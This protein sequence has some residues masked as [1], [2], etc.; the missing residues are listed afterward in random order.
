MAMGEGYFKPSALT[1]VACTLYGAGSPF[2]LLLVVEPR[3]TVYLLPK[4]WAYVKPLNIGLAIWPN[5]Y[6]YSAVY[7]HYDA[8]VGIIYKI[9]DTISLRAEVGTYDIKAGIGI[10]F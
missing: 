6:G 1:I 5:S 10:S 8:A 4:L 3:Y 2:T 9:A 7:F